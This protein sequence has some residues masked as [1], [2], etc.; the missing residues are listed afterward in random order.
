M[1]P[2]LSI[3][4]PAYNVQNY[5]Q[6]CLD[7]VVRQN[8]NEIEI[9]LVN[10][11]STDRTDDICKSY[12]RKYK[13]IH[14]FSKENGG[15]SS[16]RNYGID[17]AEGLYVSFLDADDFLPD[18]CIEKIIRYIEG[19]NYDVIF[20]LYNNYYE[21]ENKTEPCGYNLSASKM[22]QKLGSGLIDY[23]ISDRIYDWY[24]WLMIVKKD[25]ITQK[26]LY[27]DVGYNFE[28]VRW[29]PKVFM[30]AESVGYI[31]APIY[32]YRKNRIG[33]ITTT[34]SAKNLHD[35]LAVFD[36]IESFAEHYNVSDSLKLKMFAN[37][38]NL[39]VSAL[40]DSWYMSRSE[41]IE[42]IDFLS[43][44]AYILKSSSRKYHNLLYVVSRVTGI[45]ILSYVLY[46]R[47]KWVRRKI[48][49]VL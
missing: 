17:H 31:N 48:K 15:L 49:N 21:S 2:L 40:F 29:T 4:V 35:K 28:D 36:Y 20:G 30:E 8:N 22:D 14:Y 25:F 10:D 16:A 46:L 33:S 23:L 24:A 11:G 7:S 34:F 3:V 27:F 47:A 41:R 45:K 38:A 13:N 42:C 9:V 44:Y 26:D 32:V 37:V 18:G 5:L 1:A 12:S 19:A 39:Y 6:E 43:K